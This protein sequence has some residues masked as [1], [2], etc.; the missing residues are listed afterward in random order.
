MAQTKLFFLLLLLTFSFVSDTASQTNRDWK[1]RFQASDRVY[2]I[3][4]DERHF[5]FADYKENIYVINKQTGIKEA[6]LKENGDQW[7]GTFLKKGVFLYVDVKGFLQAFDINT[8][9]NLWSFSLVGRDIADITASGDTVFVA[10]KEAGVRAFD[11]RTGKEKWFNKEFILDYELKA[12]D[13]TVFGI[14]RG[15]NLF[16]VDAATGLIKWQYK[17]HGD[18]SLLAQNEKS[19]F[20]SYRNGVDCSVY[21]FDKINGNKIWEHAI[22]RCDTFPAALQDDVL[23]LASLNDPFL[24]ALD[25]LNGKEKWITG[26]V[27]QTNEEDA[28][29]LEAP[30]V[31]GNFLYSGARDGTLYVFEKQTGKLIWKKNLAHED[32]RSPLVVGNT[33]LI[34][35]RNK[36]KAIDLK[37]GNVLWTFTAF[38]TVEDLR[39]ESGILYFSDMSKSFNAIDLTKIQRAAKIRKTFGTNK[40]IAAA[41]QERIATV[42]AGGNY[43]RRNGLF[44]QVTFDEKNVYFTLTNQ[45]SRRGFLYSINLSD[46]KQR[47]IAELEA[48][49]LSAPKI[50]KGVAY[51]YNTPFQGASGDST[52][53]TLYAIDLGSGET[54]LSFSL[55]DNAVSEPE[56]IEDVLYVAAKD[57][58]VYAYNLRGELLWTLAAEVYPYDSKFA[59]GGEGTVFL[60]RNAQVIGAINLA[61]EGLL[62]SFEKRPLWLSAVPALAKTGVL[63]G[64]SHDALYNVDKNTGNIIW[65]TDFKDDTIYKITVKDNLAF[66][67]SETNFSSWLQA[68][69]VN[70]GKVLWEKNSPRSDY[71]VIF[72]NNVC[73]NSETD[74]RC[75]QQADGHI[76]YAYDTKSGFWGFSPT[77]IALYRVRNNEE[78]FTGQ[79]QAVNIK[80][81]RILWTLKPPPAP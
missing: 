18:F 15:G 76:A 66:A 26:S 34:T 52:R 40:P 7:F 23:Y 22:E 29:A 70:T 36:I 25:A 10:E 47:K 67:I 69:D 19:L 12:D 27:P 78:E 80:T 60:R 1:W 33:G 61:S 17:R 44:S 6:L 48:E 11:L 16:A 35:D 75:Y 41:V 14:G 30:T 73:V 5:Y 55:K 13:N 58:N 39:Y 2:Q 20:L 59:A 37:Q 54:K 68:V 72:E 77:G 62:W 50:Y 74:I 46:G 38:G 81:G 51:F 56:I 53:P 3:Q 65:Q 31:V 24:L 49:N 45:T 63:I 32:L 8:K 57:K 64:T 4:N 43:E 9:Q 79:I 42:T 28:P 21:A 71:P